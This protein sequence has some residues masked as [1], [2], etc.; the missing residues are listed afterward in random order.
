MERFFLAWMVLALV[1]AILWE[2]SSCPIG[3]QDMHPQRN[4]SE[5][6]VLLIDS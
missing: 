3:A 5:F 1:G 6:R 2:E 4:H